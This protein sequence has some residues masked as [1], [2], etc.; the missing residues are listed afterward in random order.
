MNITEKFGAFSEHW[1]PKRIA[2][3][4]DHE[5]RI[6][7]IEGEFVWHA[8]P[9]TDELFL[10]W[11]GSFEMHYRDRIVTLREGDL[12]VVPRGTEHRPVAA[13]ECWIVMIEPEGVPNTGDA[14]GDRTVAVAD[15]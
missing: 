10:V 1:S 7:K 5:V 14:G 12:H 8:H 15:L 9:D 4:N 6:A 13:E 2:Q 3:V 11:R